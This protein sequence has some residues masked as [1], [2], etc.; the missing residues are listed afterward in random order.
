MKIVVNGSIVDTRGTLFC[1]NVAIWHDGTL[2]PQK[3]CNAQ[4]KWQYDGQIFRHY[5]IKQPNPPQ[6]KQE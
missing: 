1:E 5:H 6:E 3:G 2:K 4:C